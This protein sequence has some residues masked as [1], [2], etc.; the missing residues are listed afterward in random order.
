MN[1]VKLTLD[2]TKK[3]QVKILKDFK[4]ICE[5]NNF[6]YFLAYGTLLG[7]VRHKGFI[8]WDDDIDVAMPREDYE[9][10][11]KYFENNK[12][13]Y[14]LINHKNNKNYNNEFS[15]I[16]DDSYILIE[17]NAKCKNYGIFIDIFPIDA[18]GNTK[19]DAQKFFKKLYFKIKLQQYAS[20][21]KFI[22]SKGILKQIFRHALFLY[23]HIFGVDRIFKRNE[24]IFHK[25]DYKESKLKSIVVNGRTIIYTNEEIGCGNLVEFEGDFYNTFFD[26]KSILKKEYGDYMKIPKEENRITH[27]L[28]VYKKL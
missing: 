20:L 1:E 5:K 21:E 22:K 25:F 19:K 18:V 16:T 9:K 7:A 3:E 12:T 26:Y 4:S 28:E 15:K 17:K 11:I 6:T 14:T 24:K 13:K 8:P 27:N 10:L 2:E 23:S